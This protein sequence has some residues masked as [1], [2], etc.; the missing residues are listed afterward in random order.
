MDERGQLERLGKAE[1]IDLVLALRA[2]IEALKHNGPR[3]AAPFAKHQRKPDPQSP[4]RKPGQGPF[5][6]RAAPPES[7]ATTTV[8]VPTPPACPYCGGTLTQQQIEEV[9]TTDLPPQPQPV[10]TRYRVAVCR[11][12]R[13]ERT[14][15]GRAPGLAPDQY[16]ATAHRVGV[17]VKAAAHALHYGVGLPVRKVP[18]VLRE[19]TGISLTQSALTQDALQQ[20]QGAVG[21]AYQEL[22][23]GIRQAPVVYTDDTGWRVG[24]ESA[25]LMAFDTDQATVYQIRPQHRNEEVRELVPS[26]FAGVL[27]TDRGK[28][29]EAEEL[30]GVD[31]QKCLAHLLRNLTEVIDSQQGRAKQFGT[32]L[33]LLLQ[34]ALQLWQEQRAGPV[35][36]YAGR[37]QSIQERL[38]KQLHHR[39]LR[40]VDN[41]R[42]LDG[43]GRQHDQGRLLRFLKNPAVEPTNNRAER[44]LRPAVIAR[45]VS[46]CSK[47][48][49]GANA[50]AAFKSLAQ[51]AVKKGMTVTATFRALFQPKQAQPAPL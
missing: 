24:G 17:G 14:V 48:E 37:V 19:L 43:L 35:E 39:R 28:S 12:T 25:H 7:A 3:Q 27:V 45:K 38:T 18:A 11:C 47:T 41:Q 36:D 46:Q 34:E 15:R 49:A 4:G 44:C 8:E 6:R 31:Q 10:V 30:A 5:R 13:C 21:A 26:D 1:L 29:Y 23:E 2:E 50:Y 33:Q 22:R 9:T 16:G 20:T 51:T 32:E 40:E 42:V